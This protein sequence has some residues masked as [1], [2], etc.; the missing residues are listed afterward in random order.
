M[1]TSTPTLG[2]QSHPP[3]EVRDRRFVQRKQRGPR[4]QR[5]HFMVGG[6]LLALLL[7][8][9]GFSYYATYEAPMRE[10]MVR[11]NDRV[12]SLRDYVTRLRHLQAE[13]RLLGQPVNFSTDPF[14]LLEDLVA[15]ELIR[16]GA[17]RMGVTVS[18]DEVTQE[19]RARLGAVLRERDQL[20]EQELQQQFQELLRQR[21]ND[22]N[23]TE[24][25]YRTLVR[26][27][28]L[29]QKLRDRLEAGVPAVA[30][31]IHVE[32]FRTDNQELAMRLQQQWKNGTADLIQITRTEGVS[33]ESRENRGDMGWLPRRAFDPG[34]DEHIWQ[35]PLGQVSDPIFAGA[36]HLVVRVVE[37]PVLRPVE[38]K[39][40]ELLKDRAVDDWLAREREANRVERYFD[41]KRYDYVVDKV[42]EYLR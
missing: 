24:E 32:G 31:Q 6:L 37:G 20:T 34:I 28:L 19:L 22:V 36:S 2:S 25:Q 3:V 7:G 39:A 33:Q 11:V 9:V 17:P 40:R 41:S 14:R 10:P 35:L 15:E 23:L 27:S 8:V 21:L 42:R 30:E 13:G 29:R 18:E 26:N 4:F 1:T 38:G 12:F 16:Q 5:R